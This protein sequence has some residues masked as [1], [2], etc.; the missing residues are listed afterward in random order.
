MT[1]Y[2]L[3]CSVWLVFVSGCGEGER[4]EDSI[5]ARDVVKSDKAVIKT[6]VPPYTI[7]AIRTKDAPRIGVQHRYPRVVLRNPKSK[8]EVERVLRAVYGRYKQDIEATQ[9]DAKYKRIGILIYDSDE[10][11]ED[12][13]GR[14][15]CHASTEAGPTLPDWDRVRL[16]WQPWKYPAYRPDPKQMAIYREYWQGLDE[17][18]E[19]AYAPFY[20]ADGI[21]R[22]TV[23]DQPEIDR[24]KNSAVRSL[25]AG[26]CSKHNM[27]QVELS[28]VFAYERLWRWGGKPTDEQVAEEAKSYIERWAR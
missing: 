18:D 4:S 23:D 10:D 20:D 22:A 11:A 3:L 27:S 8:E 26:L 9:P 21:N 12:H 1:R 2:Q 25:V 5:D 17:A 7:F 6:D 16:D 13:D 19:T 14:H 15:M 28:R 24:R